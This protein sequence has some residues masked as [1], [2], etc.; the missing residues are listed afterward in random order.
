MERAGA[1]TKR[2]QH[3]A[4]ARFHPADEWLGWLCVYAVTAGMMAVGCQEATQSGDYGWAVLFALLLAVTIA[5]YGVI[6]VWWV[7][8]RR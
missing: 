7:R 4:P 6:A 2:A 3:R 1:H 8:L 5:A